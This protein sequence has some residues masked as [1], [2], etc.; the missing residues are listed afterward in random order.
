VYEEGADRAY[1]EEKKTIAVNKN[2]RNF[3]L[4][5]CEKFV[6]RYL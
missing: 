2:G 4:Y 6:R 3:S 5:S 1:K